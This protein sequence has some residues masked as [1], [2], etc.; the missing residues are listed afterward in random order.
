MAVM[1]DGPRLA[2]KSGMAQQLI[3]FLHGYGANGNDLIAI[4]KEWRDLLPGAAFVAPDAPE[5][6][7]H[8]PGGR[9]WFHLT[10][11]DPYERW[12]G[13]NKAQPVLDAFLD[14]ELARHRLDESQLALVGFS[15][16]TMV[17]LHAGLRRARQPA[18]ILG[19]SG[20][21]VAPPEGQEGG[22]WR[23]AEAKS[24]SILL[25][26]GSRDDLIPAKALFLS[27]ERLAE[28]GVPCQWHLS[29]GLGHG[30]DGEGLR[31][32]GLFLANC[33]AP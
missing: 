9:Q 20:E 12:V 16:G 17:A 27:A 6:C 22:A 5:P 23:K 2:P 13:V 4:G 1:I 31:H 28:A 11:A 26:H 19:F 24:P 15:Q 21:L 3:V 33:F 10:I 25:I 18:A 14:A 8:A 7:P 30:I 29:M 32:G